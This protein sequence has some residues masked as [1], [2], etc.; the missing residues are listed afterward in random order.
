MHIPT[1]NLF[2]VTN[3]HFSKSTVSDWM[4]IEFLTIVQN[5]SHL[6]FILMFFRTN[7]DE[8]AAIELSYGCN[9]CC[10]AKTNLFTP[11]FNFT[12]CFRV[13]PERFLYF[14]F[15]SIKEVNKLR[16]GYKTQRLGR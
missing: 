9:L 5:V 15:D 8:P 13:Q 7:L 4:R 3:K 2:S 12:E 6:C 11:I 10:H 1:K 14:P 16:T